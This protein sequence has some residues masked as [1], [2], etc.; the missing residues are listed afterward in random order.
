MTESL[1]PTRNTEAKP[2]QFLKLS[3]E[4]KYQAIKSLLNR[5]MAENIELT[6]RIEAAHKRIDEASRQHAE[7]VARLERK[8]NGAK[9]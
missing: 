1:S 2:E 4:D 6:K 8:F 3:A 5:A 7:L 9:S